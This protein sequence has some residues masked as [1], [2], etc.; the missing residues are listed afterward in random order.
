V[1][2]IKV[3]EDLRRVAHKEMQEYQDACSSASL[4]IYTYIYIYMY[5]AC[6]DLFGPVPVVVPLDV[7]AGD[8]LFDAAERLGGAVHELQHLKKKER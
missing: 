3:A 4:H 5:A 8:E 1:R 6:C 2:A 7:G